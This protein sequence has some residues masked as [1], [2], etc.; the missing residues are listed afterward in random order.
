MPKGIYKR[1]KPIWNKGLKGWINNGSFKEGHQ[2]G[3]LGKHHSQ[4]SIKKISNARIGMKFTKEHIENIS[5][6]HMGKLA[7]NKNRKIQTNTGRTH[8]TSERVRG[9]NNTN[10]K[11]GITPINKA[12][13]ASLE[14]E[15]WRKK[16]FERDLY[17][18]RI[19]G[20]IGGRLEADHIKSW[21][22]YPTLRFSL[23]NGRTLCHDCHTKTEN[24]G[25]KN[26]AHPHWNI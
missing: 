11:G 1:I 8:F 18:C 26:K 21:A 13:R 3:M 4:E 19:C 20:E 23:E 17:T 2:E 16:V 12:L 24:W 25:M 15:E 5:K 7:W 6:S 14:Y 9:A 10:W 22:E